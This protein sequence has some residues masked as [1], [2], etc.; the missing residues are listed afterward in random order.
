MMVKLIDVVDF[1]SVDDA[2]VDAYTDDN[3]DVGAPAD[4]CA[5]LGWC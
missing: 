5:D 4:A 2:G 3:A 1:N